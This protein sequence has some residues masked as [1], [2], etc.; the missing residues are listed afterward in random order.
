MKEKEKNNFKK[1]YYKNMEETKKEDEENKND[2]SE[3]EYCKHCKSEINPEATVCPVCKRSQSNKNNPI[4]L[5]PILVLLFFFGWCI[6]SNDAPLA[7]KEILC[8][9]GIRDG[10]YC[11]IK[12]NEYKMEIIF[13]N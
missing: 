12:T 6:F 10:E 1:G 13:R 2:M 7:I 5:I 4:L 9:L 8:G 11:Q 3:K